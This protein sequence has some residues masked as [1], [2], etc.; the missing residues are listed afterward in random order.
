MCVYGGV[1]STNPVIEFLKRMPL[2]GS[3][4]IFQSNTTTS[5]IFLSST[6][7]PNKMS[8]TL[9]LARNPD[10]VPEEMKAL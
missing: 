1:V 10:K 4:S 5:L 9:Q 3:R 6:C 7:F 8:F 2:K